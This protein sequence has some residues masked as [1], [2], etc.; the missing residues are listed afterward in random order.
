MR[1]ATVLLS[2]LLTIP[3][4]AQAPTPAPEAPKSET[5]KPDVAA[6]VVTP[7]PS[8][9]EAKSAEPVKADEPAAATPTAKTGILYFY[10]QK[11]IMGMALR[12]SVFVDGAE[13]ACIGSGR[14]MKVAVSPGDHAVY[15][16]EKKDA[17]TIPIE[18]GKTYYFRVALRAGLFKGHG[19]LEPVDEATG[20]K[21]IT[22]WKADLKYTED[23]S[24]PEVL[25]KD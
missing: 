6:P 9:P 21:E 16:D 11:R 1:N 22:E 19:K 17:L 24:K 13:V 2:I 23:I 3:L 18:A 8:A 14:Y 10:R 15:A 4:G 12:P 7:A 25:V 5:P 20:L